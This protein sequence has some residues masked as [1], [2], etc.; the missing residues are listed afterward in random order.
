MIEKKKK[1][2]LYT[3]F[4]VSDIIFFYAHRFFTIK[5]KVKILIS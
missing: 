3:L 5:Y 4:V 2:V 1:T